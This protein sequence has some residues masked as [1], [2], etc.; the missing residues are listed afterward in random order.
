MR[1]NGSQIGRVRHP[2]ALLVLQLSLLKNASPRSESG[3][4][5]S[6]TFSLF[7]QSLANGTHS[8]PI[9]VIDRYAFAYHN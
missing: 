4:T 9:F 2:S 6:E 8:N 1:C 5:Q 3:L 7:A